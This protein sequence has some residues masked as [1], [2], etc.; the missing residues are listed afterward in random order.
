MK[1]GTAVLCGPG[2]ELSYNGPPLMVDA[3]KELIGNQYEASLCTLSTCIDRCP[4]DAWDMRIANYA[5]GQVVFH[6]LFYADYYLGPNEES[7]RRQ[8]FHRDNERVF[9]DYEELADRAPQALHD[10][11]FIKSYL[12]HCRR[13]AREVIGS[14]TAESLKGPSGFDRRDFPRAELHVYNIRH[15]QHHAAQLIL[16]LRLD[17]DQDVPWVGSGWRGPDGDVALREVTDDDV[18]VFFDHLQDPK[19]VHMAAFT[20]KDPADREAHWAHWRKILGD[21]SITTKAILFEDQVVGHVASFERSGMQEVTY[22]IS[23][24]HWGK[25]LATRALAE[26]L[27]QVRA[28]PMYAR[29]VKDNAASLRVLE[30]C[31]FAISGED[32]GFANARGEEV[33]EFILKLP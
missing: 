24:E 10:R 21:D 15:I 25:G 20:P 27:D 32:K 1:S 28:R 12:D 29:T 30:K 14:E 33:E 7:L 9:G 13:K 22:W 8:Q 23:Q 3:F 18:E 31:G 5:F 2:L 16:R 11:A 26:F 4:Q 19:A 17:L 6:A